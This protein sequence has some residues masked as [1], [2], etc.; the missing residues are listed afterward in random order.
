MFKFNITN[1]VKLMVMLLAILEPFIFLYFVGP[2]DSLSSYWG[3]SMQ[4]LFIMV[5][6]FTSHLLFSSTKWQVP[7]I[8]LL[9][10]T[11]FPV[12]EYKD[13]HNI[14]AVLFFI[15]CLWA[16]YQLNSLRYFFYIGL[17]LS[18]I[19]IFSFFWFEV[20]MILLICAYHINV[21]L[22]V[23]KRLTTN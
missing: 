11:A 14:F 6:A 3:T 16:T 17:S 22:I 10:V 15:S 12:T 4:P 21:M 2:L 23:N 9:L 7:A 8:I 19:S 1:P 13:I 20:F 5:N 18:L